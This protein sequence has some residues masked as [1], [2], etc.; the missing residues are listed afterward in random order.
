MAIVG[1]A[2]FALSPDLWKYC[3]T[4]SLHWSGVCPDDQTVLNSGNSSRAAGSPPYFSSSFGIPVAGLA[5]LPFFSCDS[6]FMTSSIAIG[7]GCS[8]NHTARKVAILL[9]VR[10]DFIRYQ[11]PML[12]IEVRAGW[13]RGR[14]VGCHAQ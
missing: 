3:I 1:H 8:Y 12:Y 6:A 5:A 2:I 10:M 13:L 11:L 4:P 9:L 14:H 7:L